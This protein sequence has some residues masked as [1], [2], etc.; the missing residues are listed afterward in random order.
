MNKL[1][2]FFIILLSNL[3]YAE[4]SIHIPELIHSHELNAE[5]VPRLFERKLRLSR[6]NETGSNKEIFEIDPLTLDEKILI[7]SV[8]DGAFIAE[9]DKYLIYS[10]RGLLSNAFPLIVLDKKLNTTVA[11]IKLADG[12]YSGILSKNILAIVQTDK[13]YPY[14][15]NR[16][17]TLFEIPS[18][19][20]IK[21]INIFGNG[22]FSVW[23][24]N[25][26]LLS[27]GEISVYNQEFILQSAEKLPK[28]PY[29]NR[30]CGTSSLTIVNNVAIFIGL[31][32][33][34]FSYDL[35]NKI[36]SERLRLEQY[37]YSLAA[38]K[39]FLYAIPKR[40]QG[41]GKG[42]GKGKGN[43]TD[44]KI[45]DL[46]QWNIVNN[47]KGRGDL[48]YIYNGKLVTVDYF[49]WNKAKLSVFKL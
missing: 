20:F 12:A 46:S 25:V 40:G 35:K 15:N 6:Y 11:S 48:S 29:D 38:Y 19:K 41:K 7:K 18:L 21:E 1:F 13:K 9:N 49:K 23:E 34:I 3:S 16:M 31:C 8:F 44:A 30:Y 47:F 5:Y 10:K 24:D 43:D 27:G 32:G 4:E 17:L 22:E 28:E 42:K 2:L 26:V 45:I 39:N 36:L 33:K 14:S 37:Y